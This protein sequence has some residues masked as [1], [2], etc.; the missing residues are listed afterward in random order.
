MLALNLDSCISL[1]S[2][3]TLWGGNR[4]FFFH[5]TKREQNPLD[6]NTVSKDT[7]T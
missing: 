5:T 3:K 2:L 4:N 6:K 1:V 7:V